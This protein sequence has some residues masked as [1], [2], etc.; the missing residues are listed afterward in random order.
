VGEEAQSILSSNEQR[1]VLELFQN[2]G[3]SEQ[4]VKELNV[5]LSYTSIQK[6][7]VVV[8]VVVVVVLVMKTA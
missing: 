6:L 3:Q 8:V 2:K 4:R 1:N 7:S 5:G